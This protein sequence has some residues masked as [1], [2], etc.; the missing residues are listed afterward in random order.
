MDT[1]PISSNSLEKF[2]DINGNQLGQQ[3]KEYLSNFNE[4]EQKEH[5]EDWILFPENIGTHL[6]ID[7]TSL[8]NGDLY[9]IL[10][11]KAAK[12]KKGAIIAMIEG[13]GS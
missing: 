1:Y 7:E 5:A 4:W 13:T 8:S 10:T 3:Y 11:N 2:Y 9:T 6:S 12:G